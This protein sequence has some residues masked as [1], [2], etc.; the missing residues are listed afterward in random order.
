IDGEDASC[1]VCHD[2]HGSSGNSKLINFDTSVVSP[3]NGVLEFRST[4][5]FRGNCTL[6][7]HGESHNAFDYAP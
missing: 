5:R 3:R 4:G 2:P 6:V 7:C 1:N